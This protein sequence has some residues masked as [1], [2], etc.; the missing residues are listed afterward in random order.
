LKRPSGGTQRI[1]LIRI[2]LAGSLLLAGW[3]L[4]AAAQESD[5][6]PGAAFLRSLVFP[7]WGENY[8]QRPTSGRWFRGIEYTLWAGI[9]G[10]TVYGF[11][12]EEEYRAFAAE[13]AGVANDGYSHAYYVNLGIYDNIE[14]YNRAMRRDN[15]YDACLYDL[16]DAW[17][18]DS[19]A[20]RHRFRRIRL[21][22]DDAKAKAMILGGGVFLNHIFSAIHAFKLGGNDWVAVNLNPAD[23]QRLVSLTLTL[24]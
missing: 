23:S 4:P 5:R 11:W 3:T 9:T 15:N 13:H 17:S 21:A 22:A 14:D 20:N 6:S 16:T 7:G 12:R 1:R 19:R 10:Y 24:P 8:M 2:A 18:W